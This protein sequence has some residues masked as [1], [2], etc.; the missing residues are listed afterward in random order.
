MQGLTSP[1]EIM[2][3]VLDAGRSEARTD[4]AMKLMKGRTTPA[5]I[6][7][8]LLSSDAE[9]LR[10]DRS[11]MR[12]LDANRDADEERRTGR[13]RS[14]FDDLLSSKV[15]AAV[16]GV[17]PRTSGGNDPR[18]D[19][20]KEDPLSPSQAIWN[21]RPRMN[22]KALEVAK[23]HG[24]PVEIFAGHSSD[25]FS[26]LRETFADRKESASPALKKTMDRLRAENGLVRIARGMAY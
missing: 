16:G 23:R 1:R 5:S 22:R 26:L 4:S 20:T 12:A 9:Y 14:V 24:F 19:M 17:Y 15:A 11:I 13:R 6:E 18:L 2:D 21:I 25:P 7:D 8:L 3:A 10:P